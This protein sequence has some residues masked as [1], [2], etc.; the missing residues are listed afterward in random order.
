MTRM[1]LVR[2]GRSGIPKGHDKVLDALEAL[3]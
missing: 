2:C 3:R 1:T